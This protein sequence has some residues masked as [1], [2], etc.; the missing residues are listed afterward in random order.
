MK[1][2]DWTDL[3]GPSLFLQRVEQDLCESKSV[4][5]VVPSCFDDRWVYAIRSRL[6][7]NY[8]WREVSGSP[9]EFLQEISTRKDGQAF[10][11]P[12]EIIEK[13]IVRQGFVLKNPSGDKWNEWSSFLQSFAELHRG[14]NEL[15]RNVF[16]VTSVETRNILPNELLLSE[17]RIEGF[18]RPEDPFFHAAQVVEPDETDSLWRK[19][20][21]HVCSE[22][23]QW[24][25][26]LCEQLC[27]LST[28][29]LLDPF[30]WLREYG[31]LRGWDDVSETSDPKILRQHGLL[32]SI[33][34]EQI[35]HSA[36]LALNGNKTEIDKRIWIAQ[37]RVLFPIIE[38]QRVRLLRALGKI[39][40]STIRLWENDL[41]PEDSLGIG[42]LHH[43]MIC[44]GAFG[45]R[46]TTFAWK[47]KN[48][49]NKLAHL[50]ICKPSDIPDD[51]EW[52]R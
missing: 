24:D 19:I 41:G 46:P 22:V 47:L 2:T 48:I 40:P 1:T 45:L 35:K 30:D 12:R 37:V 42:E 36:L 21:M 28:K 11:H 9:G 20:R 16:L 7:N 10:I 15:N 3:P 27:E 50:K 8:E 38:E 31:K 26:R 52:F 18:I 17:R 51:H 4:L 5:A 44:S 14:T 39:S 49:R 34:K 13:G 6:E 23:A 33:G 32:F 29:D 43:R 25:F